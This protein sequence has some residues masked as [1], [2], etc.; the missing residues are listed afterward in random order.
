MKKVVVLIISLILFLPI[1]TMAQ[2]GCCSHHGGV[3][4]C[5]SSGKQLCQDGTLSPSCTC[6]PTTPSSSNSS[7]YSDASTYTAP[8]IIYGCTDSN[9][10]NYNPSATKDDGSC[11]AKVEGCT[12]TSAINYNQEANTENGSCQ[13]QSTVVE[14]E[15]IKYQKEYKGSS[16]LSALSALSASS[17]GEAKIVQ[18]G[19]NGEKEVTYKVITDKDGNIISK[20]KTDE[21]VTIEPVNEIVEQVQSDSASSFISIAWI[22]GI[23]FT[24]IYATKHPDT[25]LLINKIK[26]QPSVEK[27]LLYIFY[28]I[29]IFPVFIDVVLIII[30]KLKN[31]Q[32]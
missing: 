29:L 31:R 19:K 13:Y 32:S 16:A 10:L 4:G 17:L 9:A 27:V 26:S 2:R 30:N 11:V 24:L 7:S 15:P 22:I 23:A 6:T 3:A 1:T 18:S 20:E 28:F 14:T 25:K 5:D 21:K 12:D 8:S